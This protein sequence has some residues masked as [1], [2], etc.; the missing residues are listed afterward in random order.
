MSELL[1]LSQPVTDTASAYVPPGNVSVA[2]FVQ[3]LGSFGRSTLPTRLMYRY[4]RLDGPAGPASPFG[5]CAPV[6]PFSPCGPGL[7]FSPYG[8]GSPF[9]PCSPGGPCWLHWRPVS[10]GAHE[11]E[12]PFGFESMTRSAPL[13]VL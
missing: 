2:T 13:W 11:S 3:L 8:P 10:F 4:G 12:K 6:S 9:A 5:P 7:P 1:R